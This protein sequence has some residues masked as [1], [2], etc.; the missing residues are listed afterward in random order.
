MGVVKVMAQTN[1]RPDLSLERV[2]VTPAMA[3]AMLAKNYAKNRAVRER[4]VDLYAQMMKTGQWVWNGDSIRLSAT[5]QLLDGQ[6]RLQACVRAGTPFETL[7]VSGLTE[8]DF[9]TIDS[10]CAR[11]AGDA[12]Q[13]EGVTDASVVA[14][15][16]RIAI[17]YR[18]RFSLKQRVSTPDIVEFVLL[19]PYIET[20]VH[21]G[22]IANSHRGLLIAPSPLAAVLFL[23]GVGRRDQ[24]ESFVQGLQSGTDLKKGDP[25]LALRDRIIED[26][27]KASME[28]RFL[29][30]TWWFALITAGWNAYLGGEKLD[31]L[32]IP[33]HP[34]TGALL[35]CTPAGGRMSKIIMPEEAEAAVS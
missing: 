31:K 23:S 18:R 11:S 15:A 30:S 29:S 5:G 1:L 34:V 7:I 27:R 25:R 8:K 9:H 20:C 35:E 28:R 22:R 10:G 24:A 17:N 14:A 32:R 2:M 21:F 4:R 16:S 19:N 6:H 33:T 13:L 3:A 26:R 12:L